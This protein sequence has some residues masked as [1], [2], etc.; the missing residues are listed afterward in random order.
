MNRKILVTG[1]CG[2]IGMNLCKK[3]LEIGYRVFGID[4]LN[5]YYSVDLKKHRLD[6]LLEYKNFDYKNINIENY[7][8]LNNVFK[9]FKPSK[10]VNLAAQAGV[11]YSIINP[12]AY[13]KSNLV[14]FNNILECSK[15]N[16]VQGLIYA[17]SSSVY[18]ANE[19]IPFSVDDRVDK[20]ISLYA[21]TK[22]S[23]E[24]MAYSYNHLFGL[25]STGLRYFTV[26]GP[27][28][29]P[30]MAMF[31]FVNKILKNKKIEI[32]NY[33]KL[34]RD[35]TYID[36]IV[37]GTIS[38]INNNYE[39]EIFN[40]GNS[41][42]HNISEVLKI[43]EKKLNKKANIVF[44]EAQLG[45]VVKTNADI[46]YSLKKLNF[47]PKIPIKIGIERFIEWFRNYYNI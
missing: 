20:P 35:F 3:L 38:A 28:G 44:K 21:A 11:R 17:S 10:V 39:C 47:R 5:N 8:K 37:D 33:G 19:K 7:N 36:D 45:D 46:N 24:L 23:N 42:T 41:K 2:F 4:N 14:G 43:I 26:Y 34:E 30:D 25:K 9:K 13:I 6:K 40:L 27:W 32:F 16:H 15:N 29:R 1:S 31:I 22:K 12:R 18:G